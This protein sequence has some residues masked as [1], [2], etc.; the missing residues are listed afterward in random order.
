[1]TSDLIARALHVIAI[2]HWIGGIVFVTLVVLPLARSLPD[3]TAALHLF[4]G[5]ERRFV[6]QARVSTLVAGAAGLWMAWSYDLW[7]AFHDPAYWWLTLMFMVW[8]LFTLLLFVFEPLFLHVWF[9]RRAQRDP[10]GTL[11]LA[12]HLHF[13]LLILTLFTVGAGVLG[14][15]GGL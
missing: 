13:G 2:V 5:V 3:T 15:H 8:L 4:E 1:M 9:D 12:Q 7:M 10:T 6:R 14:A 11:R